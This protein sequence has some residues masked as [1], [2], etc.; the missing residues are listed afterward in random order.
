M[1]L[2]QLYLDLIKQIQRV[3]RLMHHINAE[4][5][6]SSVLLSRS[7]EGVAERFEN[8]HYV[9]SAA[10]ESELKATSLQSGESLAE[11]QWVWCHKK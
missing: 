2:C 6:H 4:P 9:S 8:Q 11:Q 7:I 1:L 5:D 10:P 3:Q